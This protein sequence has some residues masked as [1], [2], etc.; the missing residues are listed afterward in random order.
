MAGVQRDPLV[1]VV[2]PCWNHGAFLPEAAASARD[3]VYSHVECVIVDDGS[4]DPNTREVLE[5]MRRTG[6]PVIAQA[7]QGLA[8]ARNTGVR[9]TKAPYFVPLDADDRLA[10]DFIS[11]LLPAL[12]ENPSL[13]YCY[14]HVS[15]FGAAAG[16]WKCPGYHPRKLLIENLS[17]ATAVIRRSAFDRVGGYSPDMIHGFEAWDFWLALLSAGYHGK[18]VPSRFFSI[19]NIRPAGPCSMKP[20][21]TAPPWCIG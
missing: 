8:A 3:Q 9:A 17:A 1:A 11:R 10:P 15:F 2:I 7:R 19:A 4:T 12:L 5:N 13:G 21:V 18:C 20:N 6:F 14:S 16:L